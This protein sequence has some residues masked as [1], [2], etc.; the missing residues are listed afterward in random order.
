MV[1]QIQNFCQNAKLTVMARTQVRQEQMMK[2]FKKV[3][4][5]AIAL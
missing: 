5:F 3:Q 1:V 4:V 2:Q